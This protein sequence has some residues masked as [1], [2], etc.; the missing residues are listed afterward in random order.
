VVEGQPD[1]EVLDVAGFKTFT[2]LTCKNF[3]Y[4]VMTF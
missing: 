1:E 4:I 3:N 2:I